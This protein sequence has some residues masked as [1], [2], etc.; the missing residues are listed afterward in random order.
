[1]PASADLHHIAGNRLG[2]VG[3][4]EGGSDAHVS[5]SPRLRISRH[6]PEAVERELRPLDGFDVDQDLFVPPHCSRP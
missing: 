3:G 5:V 2:V 1:M 6:R 4:E